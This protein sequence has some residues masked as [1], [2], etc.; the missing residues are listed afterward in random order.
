MIRSF[1]R[2]ERIGDDVVVV[3][4]EASTCVTRGN[5]RLRGCRERTDASRV[6]PAGANVMPALLA[7]IPN[8]G[9]LHCA[10]VRGPHLNPETSSIGSLMPSGPWSRRPA[11]VWVH[12]PGRDARRKPSAH[13]SSF[14]AP[15]RHSSGIH[16]RPS[17]PAIV[18][19]AS[20]QSNTPHA[21]QMLGD[22]SRNGCERGQGVDHSGRPGT[23]H[24]V[25]TSRRH[26]KHPDGLNSMRPDA[27]TRF[28]EAP[29]GAPG[30]GGQ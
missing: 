1:L 8:W 6:R 11:L 13:S 21:A 3:V 12:G 9:A 30:Q 18:A 26:E 2:G 27:D 15:S 23:R 10:L 4:V 5:A 20:G 22:T 24:D 29:R 25:L 19:Q 28:H 7:F 14:R 17:S 16:L